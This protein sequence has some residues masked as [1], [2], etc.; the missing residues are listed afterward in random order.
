M[1]TGVRTQSVLIL[2]S[3]HTMNL[4]V[5]TLCSVVLLMSAIS[6]LILGYSIKIFLA[7]AVLALGLVMALK[8]ST[9]RH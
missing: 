2:E 3:I 8:G 6:W 4:I 9:M 7:G 1:H 5:Y